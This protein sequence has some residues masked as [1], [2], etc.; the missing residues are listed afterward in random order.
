MP[1]RWLDSTD[2]PDSLLK[3]YQACVEPSRLSSPHPLNFGPPIAIVA[4]QVLAAVN[5]G[6]ISLNVGII[7]IAIISMIISFCGYRVLHAC[8]R[9]ACELRLS[10]AFAQGR[11]PLRCGIDLLLSVID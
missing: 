7:I 9:Y 10:S 5:P 8:E 1:S 2:K 6:S 11:S 4:G 3:G